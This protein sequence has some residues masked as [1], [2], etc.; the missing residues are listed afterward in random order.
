MDT[1][2]TKKGVNPITKLFRKVSQKIGKVVGSSWTFM[3]ACLFVLVWFLSG[4]LFGYSNTWQLVINT[5]TTIVTFL[6]VFLLQNTQNRDTK[7]VHLKLDE[8]IAVNKDA[9]NLLLDAEDEMDDEEM[10]EVDR[11]FRESRSS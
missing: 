4:P 3:S 7:A 6:M 5:T 10:E 8:L 1:N 9:R 11:A 2:K